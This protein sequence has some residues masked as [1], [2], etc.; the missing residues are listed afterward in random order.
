MF[1]SV[2]FM[3]NLFTNII[4]ISKKIIK[5]NINKLSNKIWILLN[6]FE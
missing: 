4:T 5:L 2:Y 1:K 3:K 6:F